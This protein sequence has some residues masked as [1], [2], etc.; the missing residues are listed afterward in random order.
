MEKKVV[1]E[2]KLFVDHNQSE[3]AQAKSKNEKTKTSQMSQE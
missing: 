2:G 1:L 3:K